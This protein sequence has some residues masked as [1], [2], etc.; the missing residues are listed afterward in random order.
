MNTYLIYDA[1]ELGPHKLIAEIEAAN[2]KQALIKFRN[3]LTSTGMYEIHKIRT[4]CYEL[5]S[6]YG[7]YFYCTKK[8]VP[9]ND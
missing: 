5:F 7:A 9:H 8:E 3:R 1:N 4:G 6:T 2:A